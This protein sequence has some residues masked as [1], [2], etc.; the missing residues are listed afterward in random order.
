MSAEEIRDAIVERIRRHV[1]ELAEEFFAAHNGHR[2]SL[3][4]ANAKTAVACV[5]CVDCDVIAALTMD[6]EE[7]SLEAVFRTAN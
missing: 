5:A 6:I 4:P 1:A 7:F 2:Y 3:V